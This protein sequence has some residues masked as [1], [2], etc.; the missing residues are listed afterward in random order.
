MK[1]HVGNL[2]ADTKQEDLKTAFETYGAV[3]NV[4]VAADK[5]TGKPRG[6]AFVEM[7]SEEE[8]TKAIA[9]MH[10]KEMHGKAITVSE[11]RKQGEFKVH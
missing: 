4:S 9:G 6:Y 3:T 2:S 5:E 8:G 1:I 11:A 10:E 7:S